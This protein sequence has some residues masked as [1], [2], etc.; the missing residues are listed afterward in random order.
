MIIRN[1]HRRSLLAVAVAAAPLGARAAA[2]M[3]V[4]T[5]ACN[6][7]GDVKSISWLPGES[8]DG[9]GAGIAVKTVS[10]KT[11][12]T[13][14]KSAPVPFSCSFN[15]DKTAYKAETGIVNGSSFSIDFGAL[16]ISNKLKNDL[17]FVPVFTSYD[18][19]RTLSE[20]SSYYKLKTQTVTDFNLYLDAYNKYDSSVVLFKDFVGVQVVSAA[21]DALAYKNAFSFD[22]NKLIFD[23]PIPGDAANILLLTTPDP[24]PVPELPSAAMMATGL[25]GIGALMRRRKKHRQE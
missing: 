10:L 23:P 8:L 2:I 19:T 3:G 25:L 6:S 14:L 9:T 17:K 11:V 21:G 12:A 24:H 15:A 5:F 7:Q 20:G 4:P 18:Y 13:E 16:K 1:R 22:S